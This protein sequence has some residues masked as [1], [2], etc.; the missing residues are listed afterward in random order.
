LY[1]PSRK[2]QIDKTGL[3]R[4]NFN[5]MRES[6][7]TAFHSRNFLIITGFTVIFFT[8]GRFFSDMIILPYL[9]IELGYTL[10][11][12]AFLSLISNPIQVSIV[13]FSNKM[14]KQLGD[15]KSLLLVI[16]ITVLT[17]I[18]MVFYHNVIFI[19]IIIGFFFGAASYSYIIREKYIIHHSPEN[20]RVTI[21]STNSM[22]NSLAIFIFLPILGRILDIT[23]IKTGLII[24]IFAYICLGFLVLLSKKKIQQSDKEI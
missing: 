16:I 17:N 5:Q 23:S 7:S 19:G 20:Q 9:N 6:I 22:F 24:M 3:W 14:E 15:F 12:I 4:K 11:L 18:G 1:E 13:F 8:F 21:L 2:T 10:I